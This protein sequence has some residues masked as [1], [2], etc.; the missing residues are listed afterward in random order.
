M[1]SLHFGILWLLKVHMKWNFTMF[2][3]SWFEN[4]IFSDDFDMFLF[5]FWPWEVAQNEAGKGDVDANFEK[6]SV[7]S[8]VGLRLRP[9]TNHSQTMRF[10]VHIVFIKTEDGEFNSNR[11]CPAVR[12]RVP[13]VQEMV[14]RVWFQWKWR[15]LQC[16]LCS[17]WCIS[18]RAAC[19]TRCWRRWAGG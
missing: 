17:S 7:T 19:T 14:M 9:I 13:R 16:S 10:Q 12:Q 5:N 8:Q 1:G 11:K 4:L 15:R 6:R 3:I 18:G 2:F